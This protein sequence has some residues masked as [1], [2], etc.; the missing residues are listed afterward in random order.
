MNIL[1]VGTFLFISIIIVGITYK[2][3]SN[4]YEYLVKYI[5]DQK[6]QI[7]KMKMEIIEKEENEKWKKENPSI[8]ETSINNIGEKIYKIVEIPTMFFK[9]ILEYISQ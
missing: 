8:I 9:S 6:I 3:Y 5:P 4:I 7:V 2:F 1:S